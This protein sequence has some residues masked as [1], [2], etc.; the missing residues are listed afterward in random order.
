MITA[1]NTYKVNL[2][3]IKFLSK[4]LR[5]PLASSII[6]LAALNE[7]S[8]LLKDQIRL[9]AAKIEYL[10][11]YKAIRNALA[12]QFGEAWLLSRDALDLQLYHREKLDIRYLTRQIR[13]Y[14]RYFA[15]LKA[16]LV[17]TENRTERMLAVMLASH[18]R[19]GQ[20]SPMG[21]LKSDLL[22]EI[23][24]LTLS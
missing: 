23:A 19:V 16:M 9:V 2:D 12:C 13:N 5:K 4:M 6:G 7:F 22:V 14:K 21:K 11:E 24:L 8:A 20:K 15:R 10:Q 17:K 3:A 1:P 18:Q